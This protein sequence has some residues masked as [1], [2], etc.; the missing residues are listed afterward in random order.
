MTDERPRRKPKL[1]LEEC[2][3]AFLE[4]AMLPPDRTPRTQRAQREND[5]IIHGFTRAQEML[6]NILELDGKPSAAKLKD[7]RNPDQR[8][9]TR[10]GDM[11]VWLG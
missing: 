2:V 4:L 5:M 3:T 6:R 10:I 1:S 7:V 9:P 8:R 11:N